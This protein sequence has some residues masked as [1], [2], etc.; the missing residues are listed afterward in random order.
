MCSGSGIIAKAISTDEDGGRW[1]RDLKSGNNKYYMAYSY[2]YH[3]SKYHT[4]WAS[5]KGVS[6]GNIGAPAG[7]TSLANSNSYRS[8]NWDAGYGF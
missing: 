5:L 7:H 3:P 6:S 8:T 1:N 2:Y 4:S